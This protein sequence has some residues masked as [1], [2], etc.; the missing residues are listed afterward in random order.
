MHKRL[1]L[2]GGNIVIAPLQKF[3]NRVMVLP[4]FRGN[5]KRCGMEK[6]NRK[7]EYPIHD[8]IL[9]RWSPR[10]MSGESIS[11][12]ELMSLFEAARWAPSSYNS[13]PWRFIY[14]KRDTPEW[15]LLYDLMVQFNKDWTKNAAVLMVIISRDTFEYNNKPSITHSFCTG[16]AWENLALQGTTM[17][18]VV[19]GMEGFDYKKAKEVL[20]IPEGYTVEA[21]CAVGRP[22]NNQDLPPAMQKEEV[23]SSRKPITEFIFEGTFKE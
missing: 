2:F 1:A 15:S 9:H 4:I 10:A 21:M 14:A 11:N 12:E 13:Q 23:P 8:L 22:G 16:S 20:H 3:F 19:H 7:S 5:K 18:L 6:T 17:N